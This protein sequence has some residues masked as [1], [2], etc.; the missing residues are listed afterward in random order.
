MP[1]NTRQLIL[2]YPILAL[3]GLACCMPMTTHAASPATAQ[4]A[5]LASNPE[6]LA[7]LHMQ[8]SLLSSRYESEV[9]SAGFFLSGHSD[10]A[11]AELLATIAA[12]QK[13]DTGSSSAWCRFPARAT[14]LTAHVDLS[15]PADLQCPELEYWRGRFPVDEIVLIYP[16]PYLKNVAS[17]FGHTF[18]RLDSSDK[19]QHPVLLSPTVSYY[20]DVGST[21]NTAIYISKGLTGHFPG[22]IEVAP[23]FQKLRK[24]SDGEDRDI[25]EYKLALSPQ[26]ARDF[27]DHVWEVRDN[28]FNYF[29]L[30]ENCSYRLISMLD[31]VAPPYNLREQF[32]S[33]TMP[34][35]TVKALRDSGLIAQSTYVPSARKRF[36]EQLEH[37]DAKQHQQFLAIVNN[38]I[39]YD[40]VNDLQV[41]AISENYNGMQMQVD[42]ERRTLHTLQV[43]KLIRRQHESGQT[44]HT[45]SSQLHA[46]DPMNS[47]HDMS[48]MQTGWLHDDGADYLLLNARVAYHDF[49]DPMPAYQPG[50]QLTVLDTTLRVDNGNG[51]TSL[52]SIRWFGLQS[53][54]ANDVFFQEPSW[55]FQIARERELI[56]DN[57]RLLNIAEGYRGLSYACGPLLCHGEIIGGILTGSALDFGWTARAGIRAGALYQQDEWSWSTDIGEQYYLVG[58]P[59]HLSTINTEA[60]YRLARNLSLYGSYMHE[61]NSETRRERLMVSLR[62]F[63]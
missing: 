23:Y 30:D 34:I 60:G 37:L 18:L 42:P 54:N 4:Y 55:G 63:F 61:A 7:L 33:H 31:T 36:Y 45:P 14:F 38:E 53:Y 19:K 56:G 48:R 28:S 15:K 32:T 6:W 26:Q 29:F 12:L 10:D 5:G 3:W 8:K 35:D 62:V 25:R 17:V 40:D 51:D 2:L 22:M 46:P 52:D 11:E 43:N 39:Y 47:G 59:D 20:A 27:V 16:D 50:V 1:S 9:D 24:Y 49:H 44:I 57:V 58:D 13:P 41:L 21:D